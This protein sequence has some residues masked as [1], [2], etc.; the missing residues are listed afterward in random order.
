[1]GVTF[2]KSAWSSAW[3][4]WRSSISAPPLILWAFP[5]KRKEAQKKPGSHSALSGSQLFPFASGSG[6]ILRASRE[7]ILAGAGSTEFIYSIPRVLKIRR[8][9]IVT[10]AFSEYEKALEIATEEPSRTIHYFETDERD[11]FELSTGGLRFALTQGYDAL[12]L[13]NP[14]NPTGILTPREELVPILAQAERK[15]PGSSWMKPLWI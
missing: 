3:T 12:Y 1:M 7:Q 5:K 2:T 9:L 15:T 11:G 13:C 8:A 14:N 4:R 6:P 10:P